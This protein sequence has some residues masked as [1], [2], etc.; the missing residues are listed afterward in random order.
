MTDTL[1]V[2]CEDA[3]YVLASKKKIEYMKAAESSKEIDG[4]PPV[5]M[6]NRDKVVIKICGVIIICHIA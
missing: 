5:K 1:I 3:V 6:L 2:L 4:V